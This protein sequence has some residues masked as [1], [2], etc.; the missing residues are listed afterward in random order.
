L[1]R[2]FH[3][4][5]PVLLLSLV[6]CATS[7]DLKATRA[8]LALQMDEK[9]SAVTDRVDARLAALEEGHTKST[10]DL[11]S[12]RKGQANSSADFSEIRDAIAQLRG[13]VEALKKDLARD[14]KKEEETREKTDN[15]LQKINFIENFLEIS[16][17]GSASDIDGSSLSAPGKQDKASIYA[18]AYSTFK[19]GHYAKAREAFQGFLSAY[20]SGEYADNAQFWIGECYFFEKKYE[21]AILEYEKVTKKF[22]SSNK[23][24]YA[25]LKQGLSFFNLGDKAS[26]KLILQQVIKE[27]P[28]TSQ[29]RIARAKLQEI[30]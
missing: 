25:L 6:G 23:V 12:L 3:V 24:P 1:R 22:P 19:S 14:S 27:Y 16:K 15:L 7:S 28:N 21:K 9:L 2:F 10:E 11:S 5:L 17:K 8:D 26:A 20:P 29:A 18:S 30:K 13:Q 4:F